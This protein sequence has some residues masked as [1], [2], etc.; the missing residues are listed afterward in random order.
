MMPVFSM[1]DLSSYAQHWPNWVKPVFRVSV[2]F[3][4]AILAVF[5][6]SFADFISLIG[7]GACAAL[8]LIFP[9]LLHLHIFGNRSILKAGMNYFVCLSGFV[10]GF[11][12]TVT[13][14]NK[15]FS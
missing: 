4:T 3:L 9:A 11:S 6:P 2:V 14:A 8:E 7:A 1:L 15:L 12:G 10:F 13:A 5:I